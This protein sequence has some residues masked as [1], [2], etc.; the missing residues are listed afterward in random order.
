MLSSVRLCRQAMMSAAV[1]S[2]LCIIRFYALKHQ[3]SIYGGIWLFTV[4]QEQWSCRFD[5][6][7]LVSD[8]LINASWFNFK[9][10]LWCQT[11]SVIP[12]SFPPPL[13]ANEL[14]ESSLPTLPFLTILWSCEETFKALFQDLWPKDMIG[15]CISWFNKTVPEVE[16]K[17]EARL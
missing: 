3:R 12:L 16:V 13:D 6:C 9:K 10:G 2:V 1:Q 15:N 14:Y 8:K 11:R 5:N 4:P 17:D 7:K